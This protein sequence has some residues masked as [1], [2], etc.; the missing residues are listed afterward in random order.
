MN[1]HNLLIFKTIKR[2]NQKH[3]KIKLDT[4]FKCSICIEDHGRSGLFDA[5]KLIKHISASHSKHSFAKQLKKIIRYTKY[6]VD[7]GIFS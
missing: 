1:S 7:L 5:D 4:K 3:A 6:A 2:K